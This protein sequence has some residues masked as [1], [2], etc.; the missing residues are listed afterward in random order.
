MPES[1][2]TWSNDDLPM[3]IHHDFL[4]NRIEQW[5]APVAPRLQ[6]CGLTADRIT[7]AALLIAV[8][9]A[10]LAAMGFHLLAGIV[11]AL[12]SFLDSL[13]G[14]MARGTNTAT[15]YGA[16]KDSVFDRI[17]EGSM[18]VG[19]IVYYATTHDVPYAALTAVA[20]LGGFCTSYIRAIAAA[21]GIECTEGWFTRFDRVLLVCVGLILDWLPVVIP[22][23]ALATLSASAQRFRV[24]SAKL[25]RL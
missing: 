8:A 23:L 13:D 20:L 21:H 2:S 22:I 18:F 1:R 4:R 19:L 10:P 9:A 15:R 16:F 14:V 24:A 5:L 25:Q 7:T 3:A 6:G 11:F 12:G 17:G